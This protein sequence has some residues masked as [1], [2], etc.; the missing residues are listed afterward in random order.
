MSSRV[1]AMK[2]SPRLTDVPKLPLPAAALLLNDLPA[3]LASEPTA[4]E[5]YAPAPG[6]CASSTLERCCDLE[7]KPDE[8]PDGSLALAKAPLST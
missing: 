3:A 4:C 7:A 8:G 6:V 5:L 2:P 1:R